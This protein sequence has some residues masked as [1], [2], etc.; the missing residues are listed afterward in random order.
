MSDSLSILSRKSV[1]NWIISIL[2]HD[3]SFPMLTSSFTRQSYYSLLNS[4]LLP[5][6][7]CKDAS[8]LP[9]M[10]ESLLSDPKWSAF[11]TLLTTLLR[12]QLYDKSQVQCVWMPW[13]NFNG[14][15]MKCHFLR[16]CGLPCA[17]GAFKSHASLD[18][19]DD[20][21]NPA[22]PLQV[23]AIAVHRHFDWI[24]PS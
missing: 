22:M 13:S 17:L 8:T 10:C 6:G 3:L 4:V 20:L 24:T 23:S 9:V 12:L 21:I 14:M 19:S 11:P 16:T 7:C 15:R 1:F 5:W 2:S 18:H